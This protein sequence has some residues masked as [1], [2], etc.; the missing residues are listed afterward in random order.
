MVI[1]QLDVHRG[2][3]VPT[4]NDPPLVVDTDAPV[5]IECAAQPFEMVRR[6]CSQVL[7][8]RGRVDDVELPRRSLLY[9]GREATSFGGLLP[10]EEVCGG[11]VAETDD[12]TFLYHYHG[13]RATGMCLPPVS[14]CPG[15][16]HN[17][18]SGLS[19]GSDREKRCRADPEK[20]GLGPMKVTGNASP[21]DVHDRRHRDRF[22]RI[23]RDRLHPRE[24]EVG[25]AVDM[26]CL[27]E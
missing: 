22:T 17:E 27:P 10:V 24:L 14:C 23:R 13:I 20:R 1:G 19:I 4:K 5:A 3:I 12:H 6:W 15:F 16:E 26:R 25:V 2:A 18:G 8:V 21:F 11:L 9:V 7:D